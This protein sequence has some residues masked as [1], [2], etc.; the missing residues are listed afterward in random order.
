MS[1]QGQR[2]HWSAGI[3]S[4]RDPMDPYF[5]ATLHSG[6]DVG[7]IDPVHVEVRRSVLE[8][9]RTASNRV[10]FQCRH[11]AHLHEPERAVSSIVD[12]VSV[13][14]I[15]RDVVWFTRYHLRACEHIPRRV[16]EM[17]A[18]APWLAADIRAYWAESA[19]E[20][21]LRDDEERRCVVVDPSV[22]D[23]T[24]TESTEPPVV[25]S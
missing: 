19:M 15:Y 1:R 6:R 12:L 7:R 20:L 22:E 9:R 2:L 25:L 4:A 17:N 11:C 8:V 24:S 21:G 18:E 16:R 14:G 23:A 5:L 3:P 13:D 10:F